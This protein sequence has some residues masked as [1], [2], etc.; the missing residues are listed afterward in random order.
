MS[1]DSFLTLTCMSQSSFA[2]E[3]WPAIRES[4][5]LFSDQTKLSGDLSLWYLN[6]LSSGKRNTVMSVE[7]VAFH[8]RSLSFSD[9][10]KFAFIILCTFLML[11]LN[12]A[13]LSA[14][15]AAFLQKCRPLGG[16]Q[17]CD[18]WGLGTGK[19]KISCPCLFGLW[20]ALGSQQQNSICFWV[21]C[22]SWCGLWY[23]KQHGRGLR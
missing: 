6:K 8:D 12:T 4:R 19:W 7:S 22:V 20:L 15:T 17:L 23:K 18:G 10:G 5:C 3:K 1:S 2:W 14:L 13:T 9:N 16:A 11:W 21:S